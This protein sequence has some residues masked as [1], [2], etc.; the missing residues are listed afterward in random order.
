MVSTPDGASLWSPQHAATTKEAPVTVVNLY[1]A[2]QYGQPKTAKKILASRYG[3]VEI[4]NPMGM[5]PLMQAAARGD[6]QMVNLMLSAGADVNVT[7]VGSGRTALMIACFRG[8]TDIARQLRERGAR[9]DIRDRSGCTALHYAV[10]GSQTE[11]LD[12]ALEEGADI[13]ARDV[14]EWTPLMRGV[15]LE[16]AVPI[17]KKLLESGAKFDCVDRHG[18]T[19]LMQAVLS[20]RQDVVKLLVDSGADL[21]PSNVYHNTALDMAR[22]RDLKEIIPLLTPKTREVKEIKKWKKFI[23]EKL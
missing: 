21:T 22:A 5:S 17:L 1:R 20:G 16:S 11:T 6:P 23:K 14:E 18:Q 9:W 19:C 2:I 12:L 7:S 13:E 10:D 15:V 4:L 3:A 8:D